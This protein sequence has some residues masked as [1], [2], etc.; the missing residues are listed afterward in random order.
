MIIGSM[1]ENRATE[2]DTNFRN[3]RREDSSR[4]AGGWGGGENN[5]AN[6]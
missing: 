6:K 3:W 5:L 1:N 4:M 2:E